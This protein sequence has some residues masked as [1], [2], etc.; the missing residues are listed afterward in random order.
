MT[1]SLVSQ[2]QFERVDNKAVVDAKTRAALD[3][4]DV[5]LAEAQAAMALARDKIAERLKEENGDAD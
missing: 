4:I 5:A 1:T 3:A 2:R